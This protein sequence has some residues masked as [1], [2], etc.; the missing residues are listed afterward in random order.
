MGIRLY[1]IF[2]NDQDREMFE[3][4][5]AEHH[6][7]RP[8][9]DEE[10]ASLNELI[11]KANSTPRYGPNGEEWGYEAQCAVWDAPGSII[12]GF[13]TFGWGKD[14]ALPST[15]DASVGGMTKNPIV[16]VLIINKN[17]VIRTLPRYLQELIT[18]FHWG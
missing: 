16:T 10:W 2:A 7:G 12:D 4:G 17:P 11:A 9:T 5:Y 3:R 13:R 18:G 6:E 8:L 15:C 1:P 14:F